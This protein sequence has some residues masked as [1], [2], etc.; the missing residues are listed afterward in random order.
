[1]MR[2]RSGI[3]KCL[4]LENDGWFKVNGSGCKVHG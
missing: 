3:R 2:M 4:K 1:M